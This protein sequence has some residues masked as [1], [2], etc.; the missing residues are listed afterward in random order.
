MKCSDCQGKGTITLLVSSVTCNKCK[1][2]GLEKNESDK[3]RSKFLAALLENQ[4]QIQT[5]VTSGTAIAP[6][7]DYV[8]VDWSNVKF[9]DCEIDPPYQLSPEQIQSCTEELNK[10]LDADVLKRLYFI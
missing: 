10:K 8:V 3:T 2:S 4:K 7:V 6:K 9:I 1:G 5:T